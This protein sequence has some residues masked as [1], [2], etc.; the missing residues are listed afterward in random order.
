MDTEHI[1]L[2]E[3]LNKDDCRIAKHI[4]GVEWPVRI[5]Y[6]SRQGYYTERL[7]V[8]RTKA[9]GKGG[10]FHQIMIKTYLT[11]LEASKV[12]WHEL[13]H[14]AQAERL[15]VNEFARQYRMYSGTGSFGAA[16]RN[17]PFEVE[18]RKN[19]EEWGPTIELYW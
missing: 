1:P 16:Y 12:L 15:G 7:G 6:D 11:P 2:S 13:T 17:N 4:L 19:E 3:R 5:K 18:A 10:Y 14:A 8:H 9:D